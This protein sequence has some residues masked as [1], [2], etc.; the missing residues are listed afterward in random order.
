MPWIIR[1]KKQNKTKQNKNET[2]LRIIM[3]I[4]ILRFT[5][6]TTHDYVCLCISFPAVLNQFSDTRIMWTLLSFH[7]EVISAYSFRE[8]CYL[9][10]KL[11]I[12]VNNWP[13]S[14]SARHQH[15]ARERH[16]IRIASLENVDNQ[17][18]RSTNFTH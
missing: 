5:M 13:V 11:Q 18:P 6:I 1:Y 14:H 9:D 8:M 17:T 3:L 10:R 12:D 15:P 7:T 16:K 4:P 2:N